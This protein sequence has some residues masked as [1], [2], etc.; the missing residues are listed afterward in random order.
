MKAFVNHFLL[1]A[2]LVGFFVFH[3]TVVR[4]SVAQET[5]SLTIGSEAPPLDIE[6]W[7]QD[8]NGFFEPVTDFEKGKVYVVEFWATWCAPCRTMMP[9]LAELQNKYRGEGVQVVSIS[10]ES[11]A[12]VKSFLKEDFGQSDKTYD[13]ITEAYSLTTDPDGSANHDYMQAS[14]QQGIPTSF[15]VGKTSK[16]EWIGHPAE[17]DQPLAEVVADS[18]DREAFKKQFVER[19]QLEI[20]MR[21]I[22]MLAGAGKFNQAIKLIETN[23]EKIEDP[24]MKANLEDFRYSLMLSAGKANEEVVDYY[25]ERIAEMKGDPIAL[26]RFG[27]SLFGVIQEGGKVGPLANITVMALAEDVEN[28]EPDAQPVLYNVMAQLSESEAK[29][30]DAIKYQQ[31]AFALS[32]GRQKKRMKLYLD[33]LKI[34]QEDTQSK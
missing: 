17:L 21:D 19:Q 28:A 18:W 31:K 1:T 9:H 16:I 20:A 32:D 27:F 8:G 25:K 23:I 14:G 7:V 13:Q 26:V 5:P 30:D 29:I 34:S 11:L 4:N 24:A 6:H 3:P 12:K 15:L 33:E 10:D 2:F 22:S